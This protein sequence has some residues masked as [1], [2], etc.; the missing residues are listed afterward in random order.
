[1]RIFSCGLAF[2][3]LFF[4]AGGCATYTDQMSDAHLAVDR[5][6]FA[7][8]VGALNSVLGVKSGEDLPD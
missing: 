3:I 8:G 2:L 5:G 1:M 7:G 6:D 4:T